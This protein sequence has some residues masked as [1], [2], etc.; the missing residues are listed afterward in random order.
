[1]IL[2]LER[3]EPTWAKPPWSGETP[4]PETDCARSRALGHWPKNTEGSAHQAFC[5]EQQRLL[6]SQP[7]GLFPASGQCQPH[8]ETFLKEH[9]LSLEDQNLPC[10]GL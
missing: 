2:E 1:M 6:F 10:E 3:A 8:A 4:G 5:S 7:S 9:L